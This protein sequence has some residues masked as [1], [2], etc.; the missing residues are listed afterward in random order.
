[1]AKLQCLGSFTVRNYQK[2]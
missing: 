1:M 2:R